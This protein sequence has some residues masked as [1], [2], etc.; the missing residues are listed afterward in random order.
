MTKNVKPSN[1]M[2]VIT[3]PETRWSYANVW[4]P[5][6]IN[7]GTPKYS[8]SLIIPKSDTKTLTKI[9]AAI[10]AAYKEGE[11]KL[12]GNGKSVPA[13][14]VIKTAFRQGKKFR[15]TVAKQFDVYFDMTGGNHGMARKIFKD[16]EGRTGRTITPA[17]FRNEQFLKEF[18]HEQLPAIYDTEKG[19]SFTNVSSSTYSYL[20]RVP[21]E[22]G[23]LFDVVN[24]VFRYVAIL[25]DK[26]SQELSS[27]IASNEKLRSDLEDQVQDLLRDASTQVDRPVQEEFESGLQE[28]E[29]AAKPQEGDTITIPAVMEPEEFWQGLTLL[30][31][32]NEKS[33]FIRAGEIDEEECKAIDALCV[34]HPGTNVFLSYTR[35]Y[36]DITFRPNLFY[37]QK[38][39]DVDYLLCTSNQTYMMRG[40]ALTEG[41]LFADMVFHYT[42]TEIDESDLRGPFAVGLLS[43]MY[44]DA[45]SFL[46]T[47]FSL[48]T[49]SM[50]K[51]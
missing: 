10:E 39:M 14:S 30:V 24:K 23:I 48:E 17:A 45:M 35:C 41:D 13:L 6:S 11:A 8:V 28:M 16:V 42:D 7:G 2:K 20:E 34:N 22:V 47:D 36:A 4:E 26:V 3:G 40:Y 44:T 31:P 21:V 25:D 50:R 9:K 33:V 38:D 1:P 46:D 29:G 51:A 12:K 15:T 27:I 43:Q 18:I 5:K 32:E 37:I 49:S 19:N